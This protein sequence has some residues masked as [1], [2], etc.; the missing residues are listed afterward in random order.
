[1]KQDLADFIKATFPEAVVTLRGSDSASDPQD[2][3]NVARDVCLELLALPQT[4]SFAVLVCGSGI[5]MS[6]AAN[7][8]E[9]IR[10]ALIHDGY[11][12]KMSRKHNDANVIALGQRVIGSEVAK[13]AL[14]LF[15]TEQF[16]GGRHKLRLA[17][18]KDLEKL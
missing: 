15:L 10:C 4:D 18:I 8:I 1:M 12:A 13:D 7:K 2:Y 6:I 16:E 14:Y 3:P 5:G 9:G 17:T 11:T